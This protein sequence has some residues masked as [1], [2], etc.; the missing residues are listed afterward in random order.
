[1]VPS[2]DLPPHEA[3]WQ[4]RS[5]IFKQDMSEEFKKYPMVTVNELRNY[6]ERPRR[7]KML[8]RDFIEGTV[9]PL[10]LGRTPVP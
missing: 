10:L 8:M 5:D 6:K 2:K 1:M 7:V 9:R 3:N 4:P